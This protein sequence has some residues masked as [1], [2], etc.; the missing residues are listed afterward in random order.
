[1]SLLIKLLII[2]FA[3]LL[4]SIPFGYIFT[5][6]ATGKNILESGSGNI[7]STNVKRIAGSKISLFTQLCDMLKGLIP[8]FFFISSYNFNITEAT[9]DNFLFFTALASV[10]GHNFSVFLKFK[11]GKGVNTTLGASVIFA[12]VPVFFSVMIYFLIK[13]Q[14]KFV[15]LGSILLG[16]SLPASELFL[17]GLSKSFIYLLFCFLLII[18]THHENIK[19]LLQNKELQP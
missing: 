1:M 10:L 8:V 13:W 17:N 7:G 3:Y 2:L 6:Y 14:F 5:K 12:T 16:L 19:R 18:F 11:G 15:S 4:G 9:N